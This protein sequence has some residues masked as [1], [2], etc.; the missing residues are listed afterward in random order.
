[1]KFLSLLSA[2][3]QSICVRMVKVH[4]KI[5]KLE[6]RQKAKLNANG[7]VHKTICLSIPEEGTL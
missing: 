3:Q 2:V 4:P 1:M 6:C 7:S 5:H